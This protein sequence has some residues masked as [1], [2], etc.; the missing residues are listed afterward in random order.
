[1]NRY[2]IERKEA[3]LKN[4]LPPHNMTVAEISRQEGVSMQTLYNWRDNA[5]KLGKP[6]PGRFK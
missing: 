1:M 3:I 2:S 4:L 6:V 5:R